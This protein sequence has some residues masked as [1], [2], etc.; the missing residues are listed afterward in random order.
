MRKGRASTADHDAV[1]KGRARP[2]DR[3]AARAP[4]V[5]PRA[6]HVAPRSP[7]VPAV[8][9]SALPALALALL[10]APADTTRPSLGDSLRAG[11]EVR[12]AVLRNASDV[13]RCYESEG[14]PRNPALRGTIELAL[15]IEPTGVVSEVRVD[16]LALRG[17]GA[18]EVARCLVLHARHWRFERGPFQPEV[19]LFPFDLVP[20]PPRPQRGTPTRG[21]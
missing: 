2:A 17:P 20:E 1:R 9:L 5:I 21:S 18:L 16:S 11:G 15:T 6:G 13:R 19:H 4:L 8:M 7:E 14:L 12:A 10:T 3:D